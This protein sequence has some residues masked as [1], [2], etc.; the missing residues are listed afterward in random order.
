MNAFQVDIAPL[1]LRVGFSK[2]VSNT[3]YLYRFPV[4][5]QETSFCEETREGDA[6]FRSEGPAASNKVFS[7]LVSL[8]R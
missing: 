8:K 5:W 6:L 7:F 3:E 4:G 2:P 1:L